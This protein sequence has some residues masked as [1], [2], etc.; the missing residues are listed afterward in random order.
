[1]TDS[2]EKKVETILP[3]R[4]QKGDTVAVI[5]VAGALRETQYIESFQNQLISLGFKVKIGKTVFKIHGYFSGTDEERA[6]E[7]NECIKDPSIKAIFFIKGG[8]GSARIL[9]LIDFN[10]IQENPKI[11]LG[12]SDI[13]SLLLA[14]FN[15]TKLITY[16]G[17]VGVSSWDG[18]TLESFKNIICR[19]DTKFSLGTPEILKSVKVIKSGVAKGQLIGGNL[20]VFVSLLATPFFESCKGKILFLEETEEEPYSI[21]RMLTTLRLSGVLDEVVGV[22]FGHFNKC[23]AE[24]PQQSFTVFEVLEQHFKHAHYP[25]IYGCPFGH[26]HDKWTLP[27]GAEAVLDSDDSILSLVKPAVI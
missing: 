23:I 11:I 8:W 7:F 22:V 26:V 18:F 25:V 15:K 12:F 16:H 1:M 4:L 6:Q 2:E 27:I 24:K 13:T 5:G 14:V 21:D 17:P 3:N 19:A 20:T 10:L 9:N